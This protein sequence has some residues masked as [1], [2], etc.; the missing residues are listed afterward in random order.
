LCLTE[1]IFIWFSTDYLMS[2]LLKTKFAVKIEPCHLCAN[3][4][5][6]NVSELARNSWKKSGKKLSD[7]HQVCPK[8]AND[9]L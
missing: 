3:S 7:C 4:Y 9:L 6:A 8:S 5:L 1:N 2:Y